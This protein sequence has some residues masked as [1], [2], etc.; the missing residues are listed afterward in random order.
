MIET[1]SRAA[2]GRSCRVAFEPTGRMHLALWR[3]LDKAGLGPV[4]VNPYRARRFA[5]ADGRLAK[6]DALDAAMLARA[7]EALE[8]AERPAPSEEALRIRELLRSPIYK[9]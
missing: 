4:P 5:E 2:A 8:L 9:R 1:L 3:A 7:A 6:T